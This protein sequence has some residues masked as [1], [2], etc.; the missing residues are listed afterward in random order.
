MAEEQRRHPRKSL[1]VDFRAKNA[2]GA[3]QLLFEGVDLS[4][5]GSFLRSELLLEDGE[6]LVVEFRV[7]GVP[8]LMKAQARVAWVRRFPR[9]GE[10]AGMGIEFL[11]MSEEDRS[12]LESYLETVGGG[13]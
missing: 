7:P 11:S 4:A 10:P 8:R 9:D 1:Q 2:S 5:G 6:A 13:W 12:I 3:G